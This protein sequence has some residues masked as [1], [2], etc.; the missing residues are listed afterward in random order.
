MK[1]S[2]YDFP[3][4]SDTV[5]YTNLNDFHTKIIDLLN[6]DD[7]IDIENKGRDYVQKNF[8]W[9]K[10]TEQFLKELDSIKNITKN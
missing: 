2:L 6:S 4:E 8:T 1:G 9:N 5:Q 3:I 7:L 10:V